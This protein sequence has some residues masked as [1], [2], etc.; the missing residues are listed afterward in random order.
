MNSA[1]ET[2][3]EEAHALIREQAARSSLVLCLE[4]ALPGGVLKL[5]RKG[6]LVI[7]VVT[8]GKSAHAGA[9]DKG[10]NA[11]EELI[12]QLGTM[13][14]IRSGETTVNIGQIGGGERANTVPEKA[15]AVLD[16]RFWKNTDK[17]R[18]RTHFRK[19][20][21]ILRG[22]KVKTAVESV[23][24]PMEKTRA[25]AELFAKAVDI[26]AALG[27]SLQGGKTG[28]GSDASIASGMG[29]PTLDGLGPDGNGIHAENEH[30]LLPSFI[31]RTALITELL[32]NL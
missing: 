20:T 4:P 14:K 19:M 28:G 13:K 21:P 17:E 12:A 15:W 5:E 31:E 10:V 29:I 26:G 32:I 22:A 27:I 2:G 30:L 9:P 8:N 24:P 18:V 3:N 11:V 23:T 16:I 6:R 25:S 1:E 7:R